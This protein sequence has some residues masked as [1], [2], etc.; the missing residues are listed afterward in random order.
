LSRRSPVKPRLP[1]GVELGRGVAIS[2][3]K[4]KGAQF[5]ISLF[6]GLVIAGPVSYMFFI[7]TSIDWAIGAGIFTLLTVMGIVWSII[8]IFSSIIGSFSSIIGSF[9]SNIQNSYLN[10]KPHSG[11]KG[12][13]AMVSRWQKLKTTKWM[14][15]FEANPWRYYWMAL[16]GSMLIWLLSGIVWLV[17][18]PAAIRLTFREALLFLW[19]FLFITGSS[20]LGGRKQGL[21]KQ[22]YVVALVSGARGTLFWGGLLLLIFI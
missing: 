8:G 4:P 21:L 10:D 7:Y 19:G 13:N 12:G 6:L 20:V 3:I 11:K 15:K 18:S 22:S 9:S 14:D 17:A 5:I 2:M 16:A 1:A